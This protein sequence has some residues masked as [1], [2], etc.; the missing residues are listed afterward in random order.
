VI[1]LLIILLVPAL[2]CTDAGSRNPLHILAAL[3]AWPLDLIIARTTFAA[4]AG[5][6]PRA[7]ERTVSDMLE[8]LCNEPS[9]PDWMLFVQIAKKINRATGMPHIRAVTHA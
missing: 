8:N 5:R 2:R 6:Q 9:H 3:I 7:G 1:D 4:V